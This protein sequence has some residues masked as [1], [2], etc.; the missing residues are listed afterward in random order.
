[1]GVNEK[2]GTKNVYKFDMYEDSSTSI[3][4]SRVCVEKQILM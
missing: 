2:R 4:N 1:V 3:K